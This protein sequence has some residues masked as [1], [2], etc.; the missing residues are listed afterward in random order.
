[1]C[2]ASYR[3]GG[4]GS[5]TTQM[6]HLR[7]W[8]STFSCALPA[9]TC[10][11]CYARP[12]RHVC[13]ALCPC[14]PLSA[15][16]CRENAMQLLVKAVPEPSATARTAALQAA[17]RHALRRGVTTVVDL[18]RHPF[19]DADSSWR[20]LDVRMQAAGDGGVRE[21]VSGRGHTMHLPYYCTCGP[22]GRCKSGPMQHRALL[23]LEHTTTCVCKPF[24]LSS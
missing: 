18:G 14:P 5:A 1:M 19:S 8:C 17:T 6:A 12:L 22:P 11:Q 21:G 13:H 7:W 10:V 16:P 4:Q 3:F 23:E 15:P 9:H 24:E 20:D 2:A